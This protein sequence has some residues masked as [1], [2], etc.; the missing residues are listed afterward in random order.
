MNFVPYHI[1]QYQKAMLHNDIPVIDSYSIL[2]HNGC[3]VHHSPIQQLPEGMMLGGSESGNGFSLFVPANAKPS[4]PI[5]IINLFDGHPDTTIQFCNRVIMEAGSS[6]ELLTSDF[7]LSGEPYT[8]SDTTDITL[9]ETATLN[10]VRLQKLNGATRLTAATTVHQ[11][12]ASRMKTHFVTLRG[13]NICNH[14]TVRL[15]GKDAEHVAYGLSLTQQN[16]HVENNIL[17]IHESPECQSNQLF[18]QIL[19][20]QSTG[21]FTGRIVVNRD[22]LKTVAY[23]RSSNILLHPKAKMNIC[24]QLEI[25]ADDVKCSHGATVGQLDAEALFYLR[26]RGISEVE[27]TKMLLQA[28][29]GEALNKIS[30]VPFRE[31]ILSKI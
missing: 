7:T 19:S 30:C 24:P 21:A 20:D 13:G 22:S 10:M 5:Q 4:K 28:F 26:S 1:D 18:K 15:S 27:A 14:L 8:C 16:E 29:A 3:C 6:A 11:A 17:I 25:Y 23:Q 9:G 31:S 2:I 12:A